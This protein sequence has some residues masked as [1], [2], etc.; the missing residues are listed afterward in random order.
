MRLRLATLAGALIL[1]RPTPVA[2]QRVLGPWGDAS[3]LRAG[4][5]RLTV[6][7]LWDRANERYDAQGALHPLGASATAWDGTFDAR[8]AAA[9][10]LVAT[11]AGQASFAPSLGTLVLGRRDA[12]ADGKFDLAVGVTSRLTVGGEIR[13]INHGIEPGLTINPSGTGATMGLNPAWYTADAR[14]RNALVV[15]QFDSATTQLARRLSQCQGTPALPG[16]STV[17]AGAANIQSLIA[18]AGSFATALNQLYGG[19]G[20]SVGLPFVPVLNTAAQRAI[21]Q[22]LLGYRDQFLQYGNAAI[23]TDAPVASGIMAPGDFTRLLTDSLYGYRLRPLRPVHAYGLAGAAAHATLRLFDNTGTDTTIIS[24]FKIRQSV[25]A[26]VR[27][28]GATTPPTDEVFAPNAGDVA[29]GVT[30]QSFT[31]FFYGRKYA[32]TIIASWSQYAGADYVMRIPSVTSP[33]VGG[34]AWPL[35]M[36]AR[37]VALTRTPSPRIDLTV[38]PRLAVGRDLWVGAAWTYRRQDAETWAVRGAAGGVTAADATSWAAGTDWSAHEL[39]LGGTYSTLRAV[40]QG[41]ATVAFDVSYE[42]HQVLTG[43][44]S[45]VAKLTRDAVTFRWYRMIREPRRAPQRR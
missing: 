6:G 35:Q 18:G 3:T 42:H 22:R 9:Q 41:R 32:A 45:S 36:A 8:L 12:S 27:F 19:R 10:P 40:R 14:A 38:A 4:Q 26:Q 15:S 13:V 31:D 29:G 43:T 39:S 5:L 33:A 17:L 25:G 34:V 20:A 24:G 2:A 21:A 7:T 23:G 37:E 28:G 30:A 16:C 44:G 11:L 1:L